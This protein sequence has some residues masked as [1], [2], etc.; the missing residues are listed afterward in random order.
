MDQ[1][2]Y[3]RATTFGG[4][5]LPLIPPLTHQFS[6]RYGFKSFSVQADI[7]QAASQNYINES[8]GEDV[9]PGYTIASLLLNYQVSRK[10]TTF[11]FQTGVENLFDEYYHGH[12]DWGNI[13]RPGRNVYV[14][15]E[16]RF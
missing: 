8:F 9:T 7:E 14:T 1:V 12:L 5:P 11:V 15:L 4:D 6:V 3:V 10:Q 2:K 13:P 16:I